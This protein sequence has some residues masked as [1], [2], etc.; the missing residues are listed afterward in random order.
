MNARRSL[1]RPAPSRRATRTPELDAMSHPECMRHS[2]R[3]YLALGLATQTVVLSSLNGCVVSRTTVLSPGALEALPPESKIDVRA[4]APASVWVRSK[5]DG[6]AMVP[7]VTSLE[8]S[9]TWATADS[10]V[11]HRVRIRQAD[12]RSTGPYNEAVIS[13]SQQCGLTLVKVNEAKSALATVAL[14]AVMVGGLALLI[15]AALS[16]VEGWELLMSGNR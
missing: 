5:R 16:N 11:L 6:L 12:N 1:L 15:G 13:M 9:L 4:C 3:R 8:G 14:V 7:A 10:V 2:S